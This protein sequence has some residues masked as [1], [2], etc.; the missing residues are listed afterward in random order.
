[1]RGLP[2][3]RLRLVFEHARPEARSLRCRQVRT[4]RR[5]TL[6]GRGGRFSVG[7]W[8]E[9]PLYWKERRR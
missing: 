3:I 2:R 6:L 8:R 1:M 5:E 9:F 4:L 7:V